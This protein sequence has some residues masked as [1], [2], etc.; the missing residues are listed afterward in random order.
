MTSRRLNVLVYTGTGTTVESVRHCIYSL[1]RLLSPTYAVIPV[2]EA[3][4]LKEPWQPTCALLVIPGGGDLGY[5]RVLNGPGNRRIADF[6]RRGGAY[7]GFCAGG[8]YGSRRCEFEVGDRTLEV[9]GSRELGFFP[10]TCRG[11][12]FKGFEYH[13]ERGAR[14]VRLSVKEG[15]GG[16][17]GEE[18]LSYYNGGGVFV[19]AAKYDGVEVLAQYADDI[20]VDGGEG[21]AAVIFCKVGSGNV[22]LT[23]PHPEF[24]AANLHPQPQLPSYESLISALAAADAARVTFLRACL[25]KLGLD[26]SADP[27]APP[28]LSRMHLT[29]AD[30]AG[31][32]E[33]LA[34]WEE[35]ITREGEGVD[36]EEYIHGEHDV[37]RIE[38]HSS[39][40]D[41]D[42]LRGA[43][44][45]G[46]AEAEAGI[47]DYDG[48]VKVIVPHDEAWPDAKETPS[49]NHR[50]FYNSLKGYRAKEPTAETWGDSLMYGEVVT[51]TN[52]LM[53]KNPKLLA[54]LPTG[55]TLTAT[56]Q[57]A[58]R[59]R[60][61]NVW[62]SPAGCLI[63]STVINHPAHLAASHPVVFIQYIAAIAIVEAVKSYDDGCADVPVKLKWPNDIYCRDPNTPAT[64]PP[65]YVKIGGILS[66]C[67][68]S[69]GAYQ[70]VLGIGINTTNSRPTTS[71]NAIAPASLAGG[72]HLETLL[73]RILT[74]IEALYGQFRRE[75]FSRDLEARYY[76]HW[77][78]GG[79]T[80][81]LEA[82]AGARAKVVGITRDWGLLKAVEVDSLGRETGRAWALQSDENSFDFWRGLVKRKL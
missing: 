60:G 48:I 31:V 52:T 29:A 33:M 66:N 10:G 11:G 3:A 34:S 59:G 12:A 67:A 21:K 25:S 24:A 58:G 7:L 23:G 57:V 4:L 62:V 13:G 35:A 8:Y 56:T 72:F 19:D 61:T 74:R 50:L 6:V 40:W 28:S 9:I 36:A 65:S 46:E 73:A 80:V 30:H 69:Q 54:H 68:Y 82:E 55:F 38:K 27:A 18:V 42:G 39:R 20:A 78:H 75:G 17:E 53:D 5:C 32:S 44:P 2:A 22:I 41:V 63:F 51:S 79:Q 43:L 64:E 45:G 14:A 15:F 76:A 37:F 71:L 49:F 26:L 77:L 70:I 47:V 81:T 1:R 16:G